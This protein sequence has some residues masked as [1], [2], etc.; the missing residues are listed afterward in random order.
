[1]R[2]FY[3]VFL[4]YGA[5][6]SGSSRLSLGDRNPACNSAPLCWLISLIEIL[7]LTDSSFTCC[8]QYYAAKHFPT[9]CYRSYPGLALSHNSGERADKKSRVS[10]TLW[11]DLRK[12]SEFGESHGMLPLT[13][14]I[15]AQ[16]AL[17]S[18]HV[19][20]SVQAEH[21]SSP[22]NPS[23]W[24]RASQARHVSA[25]FTKTRPKNCWFTVH[26][27]CAKAGALYPKK[28][29]RHTNA[30]SVQVKQAHRPAPPYL[31][32]LAPGPA[33]EALLMLRFMCSRCLYM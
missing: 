10:Y 5:T 25:V 22:T 7:S 9:S 15:P 21:L 3:Y 23:V 2:T 12:R 30:K 14:T 13:R 20:W 11:C 29:N 27:L 28:R 8:V 31:F 26:G 19:G 6:I 24:Q 1:M 16:Q 17:D 32:P 18:G 33:L 4:G